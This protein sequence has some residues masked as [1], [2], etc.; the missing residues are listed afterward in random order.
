MKNKVRTAIVTAAIGA[1]GSVSTSYAAN[2]DIVPSISVAEVYTDD[3]DLDSTFAQ[4]D[5]V[6]QTTLGAS[7]IATGPR[8]T[9]NFNYGLTHLYYPG[10]EGDKDEFRHNLL[11][12]SNAELVRDFVFLDINTGI[13][14]QFIDR[15]A[16]FS[17]V[18]LVRTENRATVAIADVSPYVVN[19]VG[20]NFATLTTRYR[21]SY[22][23]SSQNLT[24]TGANLGANSATFHEAS[25]ILT[26]GTKFTKLTWS[27][28]N[29]YRNER[30]SNGRDNDIYSSTLLGDYQFTRKVA[31]I[32]S[33]GY[34]KRNSDFGPANFSG[35]T[36]RAGGRLTP[37]PRTIIEAT[38]GKD[39]VGNTVALN[40]SYRITPNITA[41]LS[42]NDLYQSFQNI[43]LGDLLAGTGAGGGV[44]QQIISDTFARRQ[45][46]LASITGVRGRSTITFN[47]SHEETTTEDTD[48]TFTRLAAGVDW[49]R[50]LS[51]RSSFTASVILMEDDF[52][53]DPEKDVF[54]AYSASYD[55][56][57]SA[58]IIGTLEYIHT[59]RR[60]ILFNYVPRRSNFVSVAIG[61]TF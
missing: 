27:F 51:P 54:V 33:V 41:T 4:S 30:S 5:F 40:A 49:T 11:G 46:W 21:Y 31:F 12:T 47:A 26:S 37:G 42:Y 59:K 60:Q 34:A 3:V 28:N 13:T 7:I 14:Q 58:N 1:I 52:I 24:L 22:V 23:D 6:T 35:I 9:M 57:I 32:A 19:K 18:S 17:T 39:F 48:T 36:W 20:M 8:F 16:S 38:Y 50:Q 43:A 2:W 55:Y 10:L 53:I 44:Q 61:V 56:N 25:T 45:R 29:V 15:R